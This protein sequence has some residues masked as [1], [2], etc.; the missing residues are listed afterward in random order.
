MLSVYYVQFSFEKQIM[1][2]LQMCW[3]GSKEIVNDVI[4]WATPIPK[5]KPK[6]IYKESISVPLNIFHPIWSTRSYRK[7]MPRNLF[8]Q[9]NAFSQI[10]VLNSPLS[11]H[12]R[13]Q[14]GIVFWNNKST[15]M[16]EWLAL[17]WYI[18]QLVSKNFFYISTFTFLLLFCQSLLGHKL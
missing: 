3:L 7:S 13:S 1:H 9:N 10:Y 14:T 2:F 12:C 8:T 18:H 6:D 15:S 4:N 5:H 11:P 17:L 16:F